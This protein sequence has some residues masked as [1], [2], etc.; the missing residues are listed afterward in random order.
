[1]HVTALS[2]IDERTAV[3]LVE[4]V[5]GVREVFPLPKDRTWTVPVR[6]ERGL[7]RVLLAVSF[8]GTAQGFVT[9]GGLTLST[10]ERTTAS[11]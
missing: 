4:V 11:R 10:P 6:L 8:R 7:D 9:V 5:D 3:A 1:M 2:G